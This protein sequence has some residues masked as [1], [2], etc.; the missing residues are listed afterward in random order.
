[1][2]YVTIRL[3]PSERHD[4]KKVVKIEDAYGDEAYDAAV[5][6][7][8]KFAAMEAPIEEDPVEDDVTEEPVEEDAVDEGEVEEPE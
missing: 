8:E 2:M 3:K 1:M 5:A 6:C 4:R 7:L